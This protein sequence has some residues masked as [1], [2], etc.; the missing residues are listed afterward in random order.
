MGEDGYFVSEFFLKLSKVVVLMNNFSLLEDYLEVFSRRMVQDGS[1]DTLMN[2]C[3]DQGLKDSSKV[4]ELFLLE[5]DLVL[6]FQEAERSGKKSVKYQDESSYRIAFSKIKK[7]MRLKKKKIQ[8]EKSSVSGKL[9]SKTKTTK[10]KGKG[11]M[12]RRNQGSEVYTLRKDTETFSEFSEFSREGSP[13]RDKTQ[14]RAFHF[15]HYTTRNHKE[16]EEREE[17]SY[18]VKK[19]S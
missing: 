6:S 10:T 13:H 3:K 8:Q 12:R 15:D 9:S 16:K 5:H 19:S 18:F 2:F 11:S 14:G 7:E 1:L 17:T 4:I